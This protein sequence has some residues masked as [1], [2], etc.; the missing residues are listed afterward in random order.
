MLLFGWQR[1]HAGHDWYL[2]P[3]EL[4]HPEDDQEVIREGLSASTLAE[5][6]KSI[7]AQKML[8][9][10]ARH[11]DGALA[12]FRGIENRKA[13]Q[14]LARSSGIYVIA[15]STKD[16][17]GVEFP[18]LGHG[19]FTYVALKGGRGHGNPEGSPSDS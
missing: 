5:A 17:Q 6:L 15:A 10:D 2:L 1:R 19:V 18:Q 3:H 12:A 4:T 11:A 14:Q 7:P 9:L 8:L 16:Q 13:L